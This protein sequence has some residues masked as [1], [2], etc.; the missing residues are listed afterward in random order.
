[1]LTT[2]QPSIQ[3]GKKEAAPR[4]P[5]QIFFVPNP[6]LKMKSYKHDVRE[7]FHKIKEGTLLYSV[8][9]VDDKHKD[10]DYFNYE[11]K[12]ISRFLKDSV[13]VADIITTSPFISS[14]F[15]DTGIF[16]RHEMR[17]EYKDKK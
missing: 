3:V 9:A 10:F 8:Y 5:R 16:F 7:D 4:S 13:K 11:K 2:L 17:P 12:D 6:K 15:G 1:M 14:E